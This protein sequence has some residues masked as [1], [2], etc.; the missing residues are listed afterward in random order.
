MDEQIAQLTGKDN[1]K[2]RSAKS[3]EAS[4]L[5]AAPQYVDACKVVKG[6]EP[7][8]GFF[9][10]SSTAAAAKK[11]SPDA[12]APPSEPPTSLEKKEKEEKKAKKTESAGLSPAEKKELEQLKKDIVE[13]KA[14]LKGEGL[15]GGQQNKDPQVVE[16]VKRMTE[17]KEKEDPGSTQQADKKKDAKKK[18]SAP[19]SSEE[20]K[21]LDSLRGEIDVYKHR[22]KTEFGYSAKDIKNDEDLLDME[23]RLAALEKR[24]G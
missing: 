1:K 9:V 18:S 13:R 8:N 2:E 3:K 19:L 24:L 16:W 10:K 7:R 4:E 6:S 21:E 15:S 14:Q 22:L 23:K 5:K 11:E 12:K 17:L 20:Q